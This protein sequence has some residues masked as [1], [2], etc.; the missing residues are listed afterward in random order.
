MAAL[1]HDAVIGNGARCGNIGT[2][3]CD[4]ITWSIVSGNIGNCSVG[5]TPKTTEDRCATELLN[6]EIWVFFRDLNLQAHAMML[7]G[8][9]LSTIPVVAVQYPSD[10]LRVYIINQ[11]H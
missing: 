3:R 7:M 5:I 1:A 9:V 10:W 6:F 11:I 4:I 8:H 2:R